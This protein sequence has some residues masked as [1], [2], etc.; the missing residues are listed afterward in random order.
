MASKA[1]I[2]AFSQGEK[3]QIPLSLNCCVIEYG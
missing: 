1:L 2:L 3:G